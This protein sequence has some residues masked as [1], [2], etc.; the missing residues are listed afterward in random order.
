MRRLAK[1]LAR[2]HACLVM[3]SKWNGRS[4]ILVFVPLILISIL[5]PELQFLA[6]VVGA[7]FL[8]FIGFV[9]MFTGA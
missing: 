5:F 7:A 8:A 6:L 2:V 4:H 1:K 3:N 9:T